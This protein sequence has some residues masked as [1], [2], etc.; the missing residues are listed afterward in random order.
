MCLLFFFGN[1]MFAYSYFINFFVV[2]FTISFYYTYLFGLSIKEKKNLKQPLSNINKINL[3][4][5]N[6]QY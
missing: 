2:L 1:I 6:W 4:F 5:I 3:T